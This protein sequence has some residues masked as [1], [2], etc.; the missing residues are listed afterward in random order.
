[1]LTSNLPVNRRSGKNSQIPSLNPGNQIFEKMISGM[2]MGELIRQIL[3]DLIKDDLIFFGCDRD[4]V[5]L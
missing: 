2:Y 3:V 1:M 5:V 4:R